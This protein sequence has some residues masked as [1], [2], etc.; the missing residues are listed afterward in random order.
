MHTHYR[1]L[2]KHTPILTYIL[3][4]AKIAI[5]Y[6]YNASMYIL[7]VKKEKTNIVINITPIFLQLLPPYFQ[8][9][10]KRIEGE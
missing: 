10:E 3:I 2:N 8:V 1:T 4:H 5:F 9:A 6:E 7:I